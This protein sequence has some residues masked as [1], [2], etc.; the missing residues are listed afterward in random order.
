M[1]ILPSLP[2][3]VATV[4]FAFLVSVSPHCASSLSLDDSFLSSSS[5]SSLQRQRLQ[6]L[7]E[8]SLA[9]IWKLTTNAL[10][11]E[12]VDVRS[13]LDKRFSKQQQQQQQQE[14]KNNDDSIDN[15][16][17]SSASATASATTEPM[18]DFN[19]DDASR[20]NN[21]KKT[22][23]WLLLMLSRTHIWDSYP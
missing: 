6:E 12:L 2:F 11:Y 8:K 7:N 20:N 1:E 16:E 23:S 15:V 5:S 18:T 3:V 17:E 19:D 4:L 22:I 10:P 14:E 21:N 9:G 13:K